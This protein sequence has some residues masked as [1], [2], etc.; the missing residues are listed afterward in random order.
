MK[1]YFVAFDE[2]NV[3]FQFLNACAN[4]NLEIV[5]EIYSTGQI[6]ANRWGAQPICVACENGYNDVVD[7]LY[8]YSNVDVAINVLMNTYPN[9]RTK[10]GYLEYKIAQEVR[11]RILD[12]LDSTDGN[13]EKT[14]KM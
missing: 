14:R 6:N 5:K 10:W 9:D 3:Y 8:Q 7:F 11:E 1:K 2:S 4:G 12:G 13:T